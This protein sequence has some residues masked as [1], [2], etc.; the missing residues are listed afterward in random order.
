M[1]LKGK[2]QR[3]GGD[4][5]AHNTQRR[6]A[7]T[8]WLS[9]ATVAPNDAQNAYRLAATLLQEAENRHSEAVSEY[10]I[11]SVEAHKAFSGVID[12]GDRLRR[13]REN[14]ERSCKR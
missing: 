7:R 9:D 4:T 2:Y 8:D 10:G 3:R 14:F 13:A 5:R 6:M 11:A 1:K 12:A